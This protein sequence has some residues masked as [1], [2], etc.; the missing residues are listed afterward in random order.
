MLACSNLPRA[1]ELWH[2][3]EY[4][5]WSDGPGTDLGIKNFTIAHSFTIF[6]MLTLLLRPEKSLMYKV[7]FPDRGLTSPCVTLRVQWLVACEIVSLRRCHSRY[8]HDRN[9]I[10]ITSWVL[11]K[12]SH[13]LPLLSLGSLATT[14][15]W[16]RCQLRQKSKHDSRIHKASDPIW[17]WSEGK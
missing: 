12:H 13:T 16:T 15:N 2:R 8:Q 7:I 4:C 6:Y 9:N 5:L 1:E 3:H 10:M 17:S 11:Y 14:E